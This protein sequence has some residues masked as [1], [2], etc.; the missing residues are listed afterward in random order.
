MSAAAI[1]SRVRRSCDALVVVVFL[2]ALAAPTVDTFV[3]DDAARSPK[4]EMR[5]TAP[6]PDLPQ[7]F[8][9]LSTFPSAFEA[10][11][12]D[13]FGLRDQLLRLHSRLRYY[14]FGESPTDR[15]LV[16]RDGW[17]FWNGDRSG[18][19]FRGVAPLTTDELAGWQYMLEARTRL[20]AKL[21][22]DYVWV[23]APNKE[24]IY[25]EHMPQSLRP[26][27][28]TR[29]DQFSAWMKQHSQVDVL[30]LRSAMLAEKRRDTGPYDA[31]NSPFGTHWTGRGSLVAAREIVDHL[32]VR[33]P[34]AALLDPD[35]VEMQ[36]VDAASDSLADNLYML[37]VLR[38]KDVTP[39][40]RDERTFDVIERAQGKSKHWS[41]RARAHDVLPPT[42]MFH[43]S[44]GPFVRP[45]IAANCKTLE[46]YEAQFDAHVVDPERT[47]IVIELFVERAFVTLEPGRVATP[48]FVGTQQRYDAATHVLFDLASNPDA[49]EAIGGMSLERVGADGQRA[50]R[51]TVRGGREG[52]EF[53]PIALPPVGEVLT[54]VDVDSE[55]PC[56]LDI[57]WRPRG[58]P[59]YLRTDRITIALEA[60]RT[61]HVLPLPALGFDAVLLLRPRE[62]GVTVTLHGFSLRAS[63]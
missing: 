43:D 25:P 17:L 31:V 27:G 12:D 8:T 10:H 32:A 21:G 9:T 53:G 57:A 38:S 37:D 44:F 36:P 15:I 23:I 3:R 41:L 55:E 4:R 1:R 51:M 34:G 45:M 6:L 52:L 40:P 60:G 59:K 11:F 56:L 35:Q 26:I 24:T 16:G 18:E 29:L 62:S 54:R 2:A 61:S 20:L 14:A 5:E 58:A 22:C 33:H 39:T 28:P 47:R 46:T 19:V 42:V 49:G 63:K 48:D 30:D 50:L 13:T 7:E